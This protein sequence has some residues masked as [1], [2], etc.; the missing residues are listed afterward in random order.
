[1]STKK[2][3]WPAECLWPEPI[4]PKHGGIQYDEDM[5]GPETDDELDVLLE[6]KEYYD[7]L[8]AEGILNEDYSLN[9]DSEKW[10]EEEFLPEQGEEYW[11]EGFDFDAWQEDLSFHMNELKIVDCRPGSDLANDPVLT[12]QS[13]IEYTFVNENLLRQAFTRRAFAIEH[14]L[15]GYRGDVAR[16]GC[17]EELEFLG[18]SILNTVVT[19]EIFR[20]FSKYDSG[21]TEAPFV[22]RYGEGEL[23]R[24][25]ES[26]ICKE[27]LS[28]RAVELGL[29]RFI[30]YGTGEEPTDSSRED[31][32]EALIGAVAVDCGWDMAVL[33]KMVNRLLSIQLPCPDNILKKSYYDIFNAWHQKHFGCVPEYSVHSAG[34]HGHS[35]YF[36]DIR[37]FLPE[38]D[39]GIDTCKRLSASAGTRSMAREQA[40]ERAYAFAAKHGLWIDLKDAGIVPDLENSINQLQELYQKRYLEDKPEYILEQREND[41]WYV[42]C[43]CGSCY[44]W[45]EAGSKVRAKKKAAFMVIVKLMKSAG[46]CKDEWDKQCLEF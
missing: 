9:V 25:R 45:G 11:D 35:D 46:I 26:F 34:R 29:D 15:V 31:M 12:I 41:R 20:Q 42:T 14:G 44:G 5:V 1:M 23:T 28:K 19:R 33:E 7:A 39:R 22:C 3:T 16:E 10:E 13:S 38:N 17:C 40:A 27:Y 2:K 21:N 8:A 37:F 36:C 32:M 24:L 4:D 18:D 30:L 6:I 43:L